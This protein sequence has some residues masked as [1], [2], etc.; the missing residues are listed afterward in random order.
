MFLL[1]VLRFLAL[2]NDSPIMNR[3]RKHRHSLDMNWTQDSFFFDPLGILR[4]WSAETSTDD[5]PDGHPRWDHTPDVH[6]HDRMPSHW[7]HDSHTINSP[8]LLSPYANGDVRALFNGAS[9]NHHENGLLGHHNSQ[10]LWTGRPTY[11][12]HSGRRERYDVDGVSIIYLGELGKPVNSPTSTRW[13]PLVPSPLYHP[14]GY[15]HCDMTDSYHRFSHQPVPPVSTFGHS[16]Y[17][18]SPSRRAEKVFISGSSTMAGD[19]PPQTPQNLFNDNS[20]FVTNRSVSPPTIP[21]FAPVPPL[22]NVLEDVAS[23]GSSESIGPMSHREKRLDQALRREKQEHDVTKMALKEL[24]SRGQDGTTID[25]ASFGIT[26]DDSRRGRTNWIR[27]TDGLADSE[28]SPWDES[29]RD[30]PKRWQ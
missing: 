15:R 30:S 11:R 25:L 14:C 13:D 12:D 23:D 21:A 10:G 27:S 28:D 26:E 1:I 2:R 20:H 6:Y 9:F 16:I 17:R 29:N 5:I 7:R 22:A 4:P 19:D 24:A 3:H 18:P 8:E